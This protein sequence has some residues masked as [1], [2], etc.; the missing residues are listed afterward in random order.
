M[1][2]KSTNMHD[3]D[4]DK[5]R[6]VSYSAGKNCGQSGQKEALYVEKFEIPDLI[7]L[8]G[9]ATV[10]A[11]VKVN[12]IVKS[13]TLMSVVLGKEGLGIIPCTG[14]IGSCNYTDPC[15]LFTKIDPRMCPKELIAQGW[16]CLC[17]IS[18]SMKLSPTSFTL[19]TV[20]LPAFLVDGKYHAKVRIF[21]GDEEL[22]C[23]QVSAQ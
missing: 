11:E 10:S 8:G 13:A 4:N 21:D 18:V 12:R 5:E 3:V 2:V 16:N 19:P 23:Y 7:I 14:N 6:T 1:D 15:Q 17:P 22:F 9:N 20:A